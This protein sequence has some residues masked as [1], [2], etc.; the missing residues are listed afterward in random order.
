MTQ[1]RYNEIFNEALRRL[2]L[3]KENETWDEMTAWGSKMI[4]DMSLGLMHG[5]PFEKKDWMNEDDFK[6]FVTEYEFNS[7]LYGQIIDELFRGSYK[8]KKNEK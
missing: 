7:Y 6:G 1:I 4:F 3:W 2:K 5:Y 8:Y